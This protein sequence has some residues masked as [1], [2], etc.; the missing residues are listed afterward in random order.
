MK[1]C[2]LIKTSINN[3]FKYQLLLNDSNISGKCTI[4]TGAGIYL[5]ICIQHLSQQDITFNVPYV[6]CLLLTPSEQSELGVILNLY[7]FVKIHFWRKGDTWVCNFVTT[8]LPLY[9]VSRIF[10]ITNDDVLGKVNK[11]VDLTFQN[12]F[13]LYPKFV[14]MFW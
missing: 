6:C 3:C 1:I 14:E 2:L 5:I 8:F 9:S 13:W 7:M 11:M 4:L 10:V 12:I